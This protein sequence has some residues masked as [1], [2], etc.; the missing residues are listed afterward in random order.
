M[1][2]AKIPGFWVIMPTLEFRPEKKSRFPERRKNRLVLFWA[3]VLG[4][5]IL[6]FKFMADR[7]FPPLTLLLWALQVFFRRSVD[8]TG[9][10]LSLVSYLKSD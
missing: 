4:N 6:Y 9:S 2:T 7:S 3:S 8:D 10:D 1:T 5:L